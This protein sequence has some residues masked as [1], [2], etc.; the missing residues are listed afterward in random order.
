MSLVRFFADIPADG[1]L[2]TARK[3]AED[4]DLRQQSSR[5]FADNSDNSANV[6]A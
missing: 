1:F 5:L 6:S 3:V 2:L 4:A